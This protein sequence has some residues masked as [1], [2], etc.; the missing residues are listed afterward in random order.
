LLPLA[1][2]I[3]TPSVPVSD[4]RHIG[5]A[6]GLSQ[7]RHGHAVDR[8]EA[9]VGDT[10]VEIELERLVQMGRFVLT[11]QFGENVRI[12]PKGRDRRIGA[13]DLFD[14]AGKRVGRR[15]IL[16]PGRAQAEIR[17]EEMQVC[18]GQVEL[19]VLRPK[20]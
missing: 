11:S 8:S 7:R 14:L 20:M 17:A 15:R 9:L 2:E 10:R 5:D 4:E 6:S 13:A 16:A 19:I 12:G 3:P 1:Y 18:P